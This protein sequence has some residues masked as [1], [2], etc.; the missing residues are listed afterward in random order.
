MMSALLGLRSF[1]SG[2]G[3]TWPFSRV[4]FTLANFL[5]YTT[6]NSIRLIRDTATTLMAALRRDSKHNKEIVHADAV[7]RR[8]VHLKTKEECRLS[9]ETIQVWTVELPSKHAELILKYVNMTSRST[10]T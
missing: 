6:N 5:H 3:G 1:F 10:S 8:M 7:E 4:F 9:N 2:V